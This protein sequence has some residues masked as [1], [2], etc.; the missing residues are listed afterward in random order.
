MVTKNNGS[1]EN[2][3]VAFAG[4]SATPFRDKNI[5]Q[6]LEGQSPDLENIEAATENAASEVDVLGDH[7]AS[8]EYRQHLAKVFANRALKAVTG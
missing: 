2:V 1:C 5:E 3:R 4:V 8:P 6:A 7:F